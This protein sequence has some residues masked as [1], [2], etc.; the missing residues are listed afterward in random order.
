MAEGHSYF[1]C[2]P[3][4]SA[5]LRVCSPRESGEIG[6][7]GEIGS[8]SNPIEISDSEPL[9]S[10][11][12][13][14][15]IHHEG[16]DSRVH[17]PPVWPSSEA[18]TEIMCT[19]EFW[20]GVMN[21]IDPDSLNE[22]LGLDSDASSRALQPGFDEFSTVSTSHEST[23]EER[24]AKKR[25][26]PN[27]PGTVPASQVLPYICSSS[28]Q[29]QTAT[30]LSSR[31]FQVGN[32]GRTDQIEDEIARLGAPSSTIVS[33]IANAAASECTTEEH[34]SWF[35]VD[36]F[37]PTET[38]E[39]SA[40]QVEEIDLTSVPCLD[41][42]QHKKDD[43]LSEEQSW[44]DVDESE[45]FKH[46]A[47]IGLIEVIDSSYANPS[48]SNAKNTEVFEPLISEDIHYLDSSAT[49]VN[50]DI[51]SP[52]P[53]DEDLADPRSSTPKANVDV[54]SPKPEDG[55]QQN[56]SSIV[57]EAGLVLKETQ[58]TSL[59]RNLGS[60]KWEPPAGIRRSARVAKRVKI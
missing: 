40:D 13:P 4:D 2:L 56:T 60:S 1:D 33:R 50:D 41:E 47:D 9:G 30:Q 49:E 34:G 7:I 16:C 26:S 15:I 23:A 22:G 21:E 28:E 8:K 38:G 54:I 11:S 48:D 53:E 57:R 14:I 5:T 27:I 43:N 25:T 12:N 24:H 46:Q 20:N 10:P 55:D 6:K 37:Q 19:P 35:D 39:P 51:V 52:G 31:E 29:S 32:L 59:K 42:P 58:K 36:S 18:D 44:V 3:F 17:G 45:A